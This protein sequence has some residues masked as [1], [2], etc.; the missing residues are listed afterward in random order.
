[1]DIRDDHIGRR[2]REIRHWRGLSLTALADL[3]GVSIGHLS[4]IERGER[5]VTKRATLDA[6]AR[7]LQVSPEELTGTPYAPVDPVSSQA[8]AA[9]AAVETALDA[10][11]LGIDPDVVPRPWPEL[12]TAVRNL[13][14]VEWAEADFAAQGTILPGLLA[15]LHATYV[16]DPTHRTDAL[17]GLIYAYRSVAGVCKFLGARAL[18]PLAALRAQMCAEEL[19]DPEWIGFG[20]FIR[21]FA[22]SLSQPHQYALAVRAVE[23]L[24]RHLSGPRAVQVAGALHLNAALVCAAQG[25][26]DRTRDHLG[27]AVDLAERLPA[28]RENFGYLHFGP[29]HVGVWRVSLGIELGEGAKVAE[30]VRVPPETFP[31][32][33]RQAAF[34]ADLGRGLVTDRSTRD[35]GVQA[36]VRADRIAPQLIRNN[37]FVRETVSS[38]VMK[39]R[40]DAGGRELRGLAYRMGIAPTG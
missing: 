36:L 37:P 23:R 12:A 20:A 27:E 29:E 28:D 15:E 19:G 31:G 35:R 38:L 26:A 14:E 39:A 21:G 33:A 30:Y 6:L 11:D 32:K 10:Y 13:Y 3:S 17:K 25:E 5:P 18:P 9:L 8:H 34:Y 1:M 4:R 2:L 24:E 7:A 22:G 16:R 40:R